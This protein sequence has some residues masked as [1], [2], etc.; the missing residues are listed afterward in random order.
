M[1]ARF[2]TA[3]VALATLSLSLAVLPAGAQNTDPIKQRQELMKKNGK[4]AKGASEMIKGE[5]TFDPATA[6]TIF[7]QMHDVAMEFGD[8][9]PEDSKTGEDTEAAPAIW[10]RPAEFQAALVKFQEDTQ[11]AI[12]AAPQDLEAFRQVFGRVAENCK[13]CHEDF[14]IDKEG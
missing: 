12:D 14:R 6:A 9:F 5:A 11:A 7:T 10:E 2:F 8:Y 1:Q 3:A 4:S 13:G